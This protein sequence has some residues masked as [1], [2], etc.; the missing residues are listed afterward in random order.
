MGKLDPTKIIPGKN[1]K[2]YDLAGNFL[3]QINTWAA[4]LSF[5]NTAYQPAGEGQE[6]DVMQSY[7]VS[8]TF[9]ETLITDD[10]LSALL[11]AVQNGQ[12]PTFNFQG[13][14]TRPDGSVGRYVF[15]FC[16]PQGNIDIAKVQP[17]QILDRAW[18]FTVND[19][20]DLQSVLAA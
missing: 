14:I 7:K 20:P 3:S 16:V 15:R 10:L 19:A 11:T 5:T 1:G 13:E 9:T 8:L 6:V 4:Q 18:S 12:Q 17:G 2:L